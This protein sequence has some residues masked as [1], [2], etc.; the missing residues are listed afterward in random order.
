MDLRGKVLNSH[1]FSP[2]CVCLQ[3]LPGTKATPETMNTT[4]ARGRKLCSKH[5][6]THSCSSINAL[7]I[8]FKPTNE[9]HNEPLDSV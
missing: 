4:R 2:V 6:I 8:V 5:D 9:N 7:A 1:L 3:D